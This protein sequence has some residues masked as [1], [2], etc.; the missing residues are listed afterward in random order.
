MTRLSYYRESIGSV[1]TLREINKAAQILCPL[2]TLYIRG[3]VFKDVQ[4]G[5]LVFPMGWEKVYK[6]GYKTFEI[7]GDEKLVTCSFYGADTVDVKVEFS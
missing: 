5:D 2:P 3:R 4:T 6:I 7:M 1:S